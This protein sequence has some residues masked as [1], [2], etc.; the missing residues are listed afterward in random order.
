MHVHFVNERAHL[1]KIHTLTF[2][3]IA[4]K[5]VFYIRAVISF[6]LGMQMRMHLPWCIVFWRDGF[7]LLTLRE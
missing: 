5:K 7:E 3:H 2:S 1:T 4:K 6:F